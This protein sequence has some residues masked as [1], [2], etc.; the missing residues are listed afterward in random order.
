MALRRVAVVRCGVCV[1]L[2]QRR[3]VVCPHL[4]L[5]KIMEAVGCV[6]VWLPRGPRRALRLAC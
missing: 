3:L 1:C 2:R 4:L 6:S 5:E